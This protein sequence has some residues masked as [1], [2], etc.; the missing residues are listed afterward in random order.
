MHNIVHIL[1]GYQQF[2]FFCVSE[3]VD[4]LDRAFGGVETIAAAGGSLL[5]LGRYV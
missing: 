2:S 1:P 3:E 4:F 5:S